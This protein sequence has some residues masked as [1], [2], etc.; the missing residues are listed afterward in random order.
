MSEIDLLTATLISICWALMFP[1]GI[2]FIFCLFYYYFIGAWDHLF[3]SISKSFTQ[4]A[5]KTGQF[6]QA[7]SFHVKAALGRLKRRAAGVG[8]IETEEEVAEFINA[9]PPYTAQPSIVDIPPPYYK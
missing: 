5:S 9:A 8:S 1:L 7:T 4:T 6:C 3:L 2:L